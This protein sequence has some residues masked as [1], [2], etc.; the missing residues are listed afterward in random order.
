VIKLAVV[1]SR[2]SGA[3]N[4]NLPVYDL[5]EGSV[6]RRNRRFGIRRYGTWCRA[7]GA[8]FE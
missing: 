7:G 6:S 8:H 3:K 4:L 5:H 2:L 1:I